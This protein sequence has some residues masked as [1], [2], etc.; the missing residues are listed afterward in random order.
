MNMDGYTASEMADLLKVPLKTVKLRL[1][2][3]GIKPKTHES[4]YEKSALDEI[5]E[6]P[7]GRPPKAKPETPAPAKP[8]K[9]PNK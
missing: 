1:F 5:R 4:L 3:K 6:A 9:K 2:R 7:M 8:A